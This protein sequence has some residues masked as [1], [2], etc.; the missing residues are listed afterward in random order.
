MEEIKKICINPGTRSLFS[1]FPDFDIHP[2]SRY[3]W[4]PRPLQILYLHRHI[5]SNLCN[6]SGCLYAKFLS[7]LIADRWQHSNGR[8]PVGRR[9]R[10]PRTWPALFSRHWLSTREPA[11]LV[12]SYEPDF[13]SEKREWRYVAGVLI[14]IVVSAVHGVIRVR[15]RGGAC[16]SLF[17]S[18]GGSTS[19]RGVT[20][21][22][23]P[24]TT[25]S[26]WRT[27][28]PPL[29]ISS[30]CLPCRSTCRTVVD[31]AATRKSWR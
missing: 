23:S 9:G 30:W 14:I 17:L 25:G 6:C 4:Q 8:V 16:S 5:E 10:G 13:R 24:C 21:L 15:H 12:R 3:I 29:R 11:L 7:V 18:W 26:W 27:T 1:R 28:T 19:R 2:A 31:T 22:T 20:D